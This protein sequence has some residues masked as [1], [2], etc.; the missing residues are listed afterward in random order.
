MK[1]VGGT[2]RLVMI[3][4]TEQLRFCVESFRCYKLLDEKGAATLRIS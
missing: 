4:G 1:S 2:D 3:R